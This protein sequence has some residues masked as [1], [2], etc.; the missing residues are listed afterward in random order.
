[1]EERGVECWGEWDKEGDEGVGGVCWECGC[2]GACFLRD[3]VLRGLWDILGGKVC[4]IRG[5]KPMLTGYIEETN[6]RTMAL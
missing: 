2:A 5:N 4:E 1:M 3:F 6:E